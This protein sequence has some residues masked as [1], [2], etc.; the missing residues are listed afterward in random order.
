MYLAIAKENMDVV[1]NLK[2]LYWRKR[3]ALIS[4]SR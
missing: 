4:S 1:A 3:V 2:P